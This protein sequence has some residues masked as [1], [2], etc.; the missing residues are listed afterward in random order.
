[1]PDS[2]WRVHVNDVQCVPV[3][4]GVYIYHIWKL[5]KCKLLQHSTPVYHILH[6]VLGIYC[7]IHRSEY[8]IDEWLKKC[9]IPFVSTLKHQHIPV[10]TICTSTYSC[11]LVHTNSSDLVQPQVPRIEVECASDWVGILLFVV[12]MIASLNHTR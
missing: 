9:I 12:M 7:E 2:E 5:L 10:C 11:I 3:H 1:M 4:T 6:T 8:C